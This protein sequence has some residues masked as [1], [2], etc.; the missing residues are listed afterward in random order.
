MQ[1]NVSEDIFAG[2]SA[3]LRGGESGHV[4]FLQV[5]KGRDVG[6]LQIEV[7][8]SKIRYVQQLDDG[9]MR[10]RMHSLPRMQPNRCRGCRLYPSSYAVAVLLSR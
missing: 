4:E 9:A 8:E 7:F 6:I 5:G 3:T 10:G 2:Y 1:I